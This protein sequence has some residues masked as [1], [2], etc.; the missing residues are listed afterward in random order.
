MRNKTKYLLCIALALVL[1]VLPSCSMFWSSNPTYSGGQMLDD[2]LMSSMRDEV[3]GEKT[4]I[5][6]QKVS[7]EI[8]EDENESENSDEITTEE[9]ESEN[10]HEITTE[11]NE[12]ENSHEKTESSESQDNTESSKINEESSTKHDQEESSTKH[13][14]EESST[15]HD[16]EESDTPVYWT[17]NGGVYHLFRDCSYIKSSAE[18]IS[19]TV[20]EA[21][22]A[23]KSD[24]CSRCQNRKDKE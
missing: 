4:E 2:E 15:K 17:E 1:I 23:G 20:E 3:L 10:S 11:E 18:V 14:Q 7:D 8:T 9:N 22:D 24:A 5:S 6:D 13:D 21:N 16:H 12:S 19:G